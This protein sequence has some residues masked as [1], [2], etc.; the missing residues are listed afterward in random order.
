VRECRGSALCSAPLRYPPRAHRVEQQQHRQRHRLAVIGPLTKVSGL[1]PLAIKLWRKV[2][3]VESAST[4]ATTNVRQRI[5]QLAQ[6]VAD[7][8][9][10]DR[11]EHVEHAV[12]EPTRTSDT[13]SHIVE[14]SVAGYAPHWRT[15]GVGPSRGLTSYSIDVRRPLGAGNCAAIHC[16]TVNAFTVLR[17]PRIYGTPHA[18]RLRYQSRQRRRRC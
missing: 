16:P 12:V 7:Q 1:P 14:T 15:A 9:K 8:T 17:A 11:N 18:Q 10:D 3:S 13:Q 2:R 4:S 5:L 6:P